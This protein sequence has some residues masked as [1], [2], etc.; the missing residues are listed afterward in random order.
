[1]HCLTSGLSDLQAASSR[2][3]GAQSAPLSAPMPLARPGS[4]AAPCR[5][6]DRCRLD[7]S[8][9]S[10]EALGCCGT[11]DTGVAHEGV[12]VVQSQGVQ[13]HVS[14]MDGPV[15]ELGPDTPNGAG[16]LISLAQG[17]AS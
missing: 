9:V 12:V 4:D 6:R 5:S 16:Q 2:F 8:E 11:V 14:H 17:L 15:D 10:R 1:M 13:M 3:G 7:V